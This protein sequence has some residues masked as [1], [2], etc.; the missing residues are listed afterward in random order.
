MELKELN[1]LARRLR[2]ALGLSGVI[3]SHG[4]MLDLVASLAG[5]RNWPEA[6]AFPERIAETSLTEDAVA[7]LRSRIEGVFSKALPQKV[8]M[9][10]LSADPSSLVRTAPAAKPLCLPTD[11]YTE[12]IPQLFARF[13]D[14]I[15]E[16]HWLRR[17]QLIEEELRGAAHLRD[18]LLE[19]NEI[20]L[21]LAYCSAMV[22]Q[23]GGFPVAAVNDRSLY[24]TFRF[25]AQA[26]ALVDSHALQ[27]KQL[28]R[29]VHG[30]FKKPDE[31][32]AMQFELTVATH[33]IK[34]G[35]T[36]ILPEMSGSGTFDLLIPSLGTDG[37]EVECKSVSQDK[38]RKIHRREALECFNVL[39]RSLEQSARNLHSGLVVVIT[40]P[41]RL[42]KEQSAQRELYA[43]IS[44]AVMQGQSTVLADGT[45]VRLKGFD[46]HRYPSLGPEMTLK[47]RA[48]IDEISGTSNREVM[49][50]GR[51]DAGAVV[52]VLQSAKEDSFLGYVFN[53]VDDAAR[54]QLS[55][56]RAG[57]VLVG[58]DGISPAELVE[59]AAQDKDPTQPPTALRVEVS[60][61]LRD[62]SKAHL[63][64]V[65]F[66]SGSGFEVAANG[67]LSS[68][69]TAYQF[70]RSE[71]PFWHSDF[72]GLFLSL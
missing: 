59:T 62:T 16:P 29:R 55:K 31:M 60:N 36:V 57:I 61:F 66:M 9:E 67:E 17:A 25:V 4:Q 52:V 46:S 45:E 32:R 33:F 30:A 20:A 1:Q 42:P 56:K 22:K 40:V 23:H 39:R 65:G 49:I 8:L 58:F 34:R 13:R 72:S 71:S 24:A 6:S 26:L 43:T 19:K 44:R 53:T 63:V 14:V 37:L 50:V 69:G 7:R 47:V 54:R 41:E 3:A 64:G 27:A 51:K 15:G 2:G 5:L 48:D 35:K 12:A 28:V 38:G 10:M 68:G 70:P 21:A 11:L 18:H